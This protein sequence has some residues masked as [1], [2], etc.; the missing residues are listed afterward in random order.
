MVRVP[1]LNK[2]SELFAWQSI[3]LIEKGFLTLEK[4]PYF[5]ILIIKNGKYQ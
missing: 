4:I 2:P 5:E 3:V 1:F